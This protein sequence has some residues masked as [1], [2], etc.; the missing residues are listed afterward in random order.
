MTVLDMFRLDGRTALVTGAT[1]GL[2]AAIAQALAEAGADVVCH[3]RDTMPE[4]T[5]AYIRSCGRRAG[6]PRR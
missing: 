5:M 2:G 4:Q 1:A 3:D 6:R